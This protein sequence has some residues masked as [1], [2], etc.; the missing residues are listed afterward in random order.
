MKSVILLDNSGLLCYVY[1]DQ[2]GHE[3]AVQLLDSAGKSIT[4]SYVLAELVALAQVRRYPRLATLE[5]ITDLLE[6]P[7][8]ETV[9]IDE[10]GSS[11]F[12]V[13]IFVMN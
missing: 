3:E 10:P 8:I 7:D 2:P 4:H 11:G 6:N 1:R 13:L 12:R 5:F 9:W